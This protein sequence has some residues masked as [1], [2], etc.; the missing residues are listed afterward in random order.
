M[1]GCAY[2]H[3]KCIKNIA[4]KDKQIIHKKCS[5]SQRKRFFIISG[6]IFRCSSG[7]QNVMHGITN[8]RNSLHPLIS[9]VNS[10]DGEAQ[11]V[12]KQMHVCAPGGTA[13]E[14]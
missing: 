7:Q 6:P 10:S 13:K 1:C 3:G 2:V 14:S 8:Y 5:P 4:M 11:L 9:K 12:F